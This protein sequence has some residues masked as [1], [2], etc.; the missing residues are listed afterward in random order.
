MQP[1]RHTTR[2]WRSLLVHGLVVSIIACS[3]P[4]TPAPIA[5][6]VPAP[7]TTPTAPASAVGSVRGLVEKG[8]AAFREGRLFEPPGDSAL[9]HYVEALAMEASDESARAALG[10]LFPLALAR[11]ETAIAAGDVNVATRLLGKLE[12]AYAESPALKALQARLAAQQPRTP[13]SATSS[14][15][16]TIG[17]LAY[18]PL[19][20]RTAPTATA[21]D[22]TVPAVQQS[23]NAPP[24]SATASSADT[25]SA[26]TTSETS[27]PAVDELDPPVVD[28]DSEATASAVNPAA[29]QSSA[30]AASTPPRVVTRVAPEYPALARQRRIEGWV[31]LE[32]VVGVDGRVRDVRVLDSYPNRVFDS[33]AERSLLR[34]QFVPGTRD[35]EP[36]ETVGRTRLDFALDTGG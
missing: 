16:E 22:V 30:V 21:T 20:A 11:I 27:T 34:W 24:A 17:T 13:P 3:E 19:A 5:T 6:P 14:V 9:D 29:A 8:N 18:A 28:A 4:E 32:Y 2:L 36:S 35:G 1:N 23:A 25:P 26:T 12:S 33:A 7:A 31:E 10:D 15:N